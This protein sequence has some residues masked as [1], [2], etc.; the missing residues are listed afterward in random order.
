MCAD[1]EVLAK[2]YL[3]I[4]TFDRPVIDVLFL[5]TLD[6]DLVI[7]SIVF[8][9]VVVFS[10]KVRRKRRISSDWLGQVRQGSSASLNLEECSIFRQFALSGLR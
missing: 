7:E 6:K 9:F 3:K 5:V 8:D 1:L 10:I 2:L 4:D